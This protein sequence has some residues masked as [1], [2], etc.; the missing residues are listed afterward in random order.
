MKVLF[1]IILFI[2]TVCSLNGQIVSIE[3]G[4]TYYA[5]KYKTNMHRDIIGTRIANDNYFLK[6][7]YSHWVEERFLLSGSYSKYPVS[8]SFRFY[9]ENEGGVIGWSGTNVKR[10]DVGLSYLLFPNSNFILHPKIGF[11]I[12]KSLPDGIG[13][14]CNDIPSGIKPDNFE[15][16]R[17]IEANAFS[18]TQLVSIIGVKFGYTFWGRI[19]LF[20]DIQQVFGNKTIQELKMSYSYKGIEQPEAVSYSDGT[21]RFYALG[22]G[23]RFVKPKSK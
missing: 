23:Y 7:Q 12:Q 17:N 10:F 14:I 22:L 16:L 9:K 8:T 3:F 19:E 11:G 18:N 1:I 13:C 6:F 5:S 2:H 21:G 15:L 20:M 4:P